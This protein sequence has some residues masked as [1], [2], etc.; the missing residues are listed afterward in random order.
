MSLQEDTSSTQVAV[1][2]LKF[3]YPSGPWTIT[4]IIENPDP[5][6]PNPVIIR[7]RTFY[8]RQAS[9]L[10][11]YIEANNGQVNLYWQINPLRLD[12]GNKAKLEHVKEIQRFHVDLDP[13]KGFDRDSERKLITELLEDAPRLK[14]IGLPGIPTLI[15]DSG[16][17]FWGFWNL[18]EPLPLEG[19]ISELREAAA[20]Y[21][22]TNRWIAEVFNAAL[23]TD[24]I[25][26][27]CHN[28]DRIARLPGT[29]NIP[30]HKKLAA[31]FPRCTARIIA[32]NKDA[33]YTPAQFNQSEV[34]SWGAGATEEDFKRIQI[35][36]IVRL[37][38]TSNDAWEIAQELKRQFPQVGEKTL[39]L[40]TLGE[41]LDDS[42][43]G[44]KDKE[45]VK[46]LAINR[47]RA[48]WRVN[49]SLQQLDVP[50]N[51]ILGILCDER[52]PISAHAREPI[53]ENTGRRGAKRTGRELI[54]F[55]EHQIR[56]CSVS[57]AKQREEKERAEAL[58]ADERTADALESST[59]T[60]TDG[61]SAETK[62]SP[63]KK[64][65]TTPAEVVRHLNE[66]HAVLLQEGGKTR[67][68]C[69]SKS[70]LEG[71][72]R[73][74]AVMQTFED[75]KKR[76]MNRMVSV[77]KNKDDQPIF[78]EW[79]EVWLKNAQRREYLELRFL[80]GQPEVVDGYLN[81]WRGFACSPIA[82]D[83][84][85]M[86][87][88]IYKVLAE[89]N[90][91]YNEYILNWAAW[92]VQNPDKQAEVA[93]VFRGKEGAGKGIF[94]RS[95]QYMFG[96][97]GLH[98]RST[99]HLVGKFNSHLRDCCLLFADEAIAPGRKEEENILKG[100][101]TEPEIPIE[102][103]GYDVKAAK[104]H[105]HIIMASNEDWVIPASIDDRRFAVF[106]ATDEH[107]QDKAYFNAILEQM[108]DGGQSAML[109]ELLNRDLGNWHPRDNIPQ[110]EALKQQK[111]RSLRPEDDLIFDILKEGVIPGESIPNNEHCVYSNVKNSTEGLF[112]QMR[113]MEPRLRN[114]SDKT[115]GQA[116]AKFG[117]KRIIKYNRR[118]WL[119][120]PLSE[121][122][123]NWDQVMR[124]KY[125]WDTSI[126]EWSDQRDAAPEEYEDVPF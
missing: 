96:Q 42:E 37:L 91:E 53:D 47:S 104:S 21:G 38:P 22:R 110:T 50:L 43:E 10:A 8:E 57:I 54:R 49:R 44:L 123:A 80:P 92:S 95:L 30:D 109:H 55:N 70:E 108:K 23:K 99:T 7:G 48:H 34:R 19:A 15:I 63:N 29:V 88:H 11:R 58:L 75:F 26:D 13:R 14:E 82:G 52:L 68:L 61:Q 69:W 112:A 45:T 46:G 35:G 24:E 79:G 9:D 111:E 85:L 27:Q 32:M 28:V 31:G 114:A 90:E 81:L 73:D 125:A 86:K 67:V 71:D 98:I 105:L 106:N 126:V 66:K 41:Y 97:H 78:K 39:E 51:V 60:H 33:L 36:E 83:W 87:Q 65:P 94:A 16:N 6:A 62:A 1:D 113:M 89:S 119:F 103:K 2:F 74:I 124:W 120:P 100:L 4:S 102:R 101:I 77:G 116:C 118:G 12:P 56:K 5:Q 121:M 18:T 84:S 72:N 59:S 122:R 115:L 107:L 25:G 64:K 17:G 76:Y 93:I 3:I 117:C 40:I 20:E